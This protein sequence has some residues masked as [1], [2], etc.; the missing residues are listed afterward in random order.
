M[1]PYFVNEKEF[2]Y[3][4][5]GEKVTFDE[6]CARITNINRSVFKYRVNAGWRTWKELGRSTAKTLA[7]ARATYKRQT[8]AKIRG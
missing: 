3:T 5:D 8:S 7:E 2:K 4:V 6:I 1:G